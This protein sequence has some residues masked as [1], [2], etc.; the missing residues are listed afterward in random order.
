[1]QV[2]TILG[3]ENAPLHLW[4]TLATEYYRY[5]TTDASP[6]PPPPPRQNKTPDF[7]SILE[8]ALLK[9]D[10]TYKDHDK[11]Q[12]RAYDS[13]AAHYVQEAN[14]EKN[15]V[16]FYFSPGSASTLTLLLLLLLPFLLFLITSARTRRGSCSPVPP[17]STPLLTRSSCMSSSTDSY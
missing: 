13:L 12:M 16:C 7:V 11:D 3:Q 15:K 5:T 17:S 10:V 2:L 4:V 14:K 6:D 1:M 9:A 8:Q